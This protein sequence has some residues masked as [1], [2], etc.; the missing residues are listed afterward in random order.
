ME[1]EAAD[2]HQL[3]QKKKYMNI[4][5]MSDDDDELEHSGLIF[6]VLRK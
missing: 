2:E 6:F 1:E 4:Q 3:M 5:S